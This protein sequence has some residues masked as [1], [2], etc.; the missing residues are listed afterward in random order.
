M[1]LKEDPNISS[2]VATLHYEF[3][4]DKGEL[5]NQLK[6]EQDH[7]QCVVSNENDIPGL[8]FG[9][10]QQPVV[11]DYADGINTIQF[12]NSLGN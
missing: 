2:P 9:T 5:I 8:P 6:Q 1:I 7:I 12:V 3:Y 4:T 10:T 11:N